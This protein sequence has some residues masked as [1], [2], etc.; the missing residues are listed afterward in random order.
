[1]TPDHYAILG[2][3]PSSEDVEIR[4][5]YLGLM[6]RY[7]PDRNSSPEAAERARAITTAYAVLSDWDRRAEYD[8]K[9]ARLRS[10]EATMNVAPRRPPPSPS[11][12]FAVAAVSLLLL[13]AIRPPLFVRELPERAPAAAPVHKAAAPKPDP[14]AYCRSPATRDQIRRELFR[15]AARLRGKD[16][17][18]FDRIAGH[19]LIR[20]DSPELRH[21]DDK[22]GT[23]RCEAWVALDLPPGVAVLG[24]RRNLMADIGY[25]VKTARGGRGSVRLSGEGLIV[26]PLATLAQIA[27]PAEEPPEATAIEPRLAEAR[28]RLDQP[29]PPKPA[30]AP[31]P[32][33]MAPQPA[34][35]APQIAKAASQPARATQIAEAAAQPARPTAQAATPQP[36]PSFS[37]QIARGR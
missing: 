35:A 11:A 12:M 34:R 23:V 26:T 2:V 33:R 36:R 3:S 29:P 1:M 15:R 22:R 14:A 27:R 10:L 28:P 20:I 37:C 18:A 25:T 4:T 7:H 17:A 21:A 32:A 16:Q 19:A 24:G 9:R 5:A 31:P 8:L 6:R 13:V 30:P